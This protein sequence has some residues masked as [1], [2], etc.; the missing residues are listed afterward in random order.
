MLVRIIYMLAKNKYSTMEGEKGGNNSK[1]ER[2]KVLH[3]ARCLI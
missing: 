1:M 2:I 3:V